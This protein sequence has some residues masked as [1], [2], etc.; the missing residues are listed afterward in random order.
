[1]LKALLF[2]IYLRISATRFTEHLQL[3]KIQNVRGPELSESIEILEN[4]EMSTETDS[5]QYLHPSSCHPYNCV[6]SIP[7]SQA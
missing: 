4:N 7:Y 2:Q 1:M 5:H 6:K 3:S